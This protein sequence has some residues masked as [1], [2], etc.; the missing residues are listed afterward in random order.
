[1]EGGSTP[2]K[3]LKIGKLALGG[4]GEPHE[5]ADRA[6]ISRIKVTSTGLF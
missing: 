3:K 5:Q 2:K 1:M 4:G 6:K